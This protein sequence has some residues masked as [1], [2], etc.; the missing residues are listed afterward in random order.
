MRRSDP[1]AEKMRK[2]MLSHS[3]RAVYQSGTRGDNLH[4]QVRAT[5][6]GGIGDNRRRQRCE[7]FREVAAINGNTRQAASVG[8]DVNGQFPERYTAR[9]SRLTGPSRAHPYI[10]ART[11]RAL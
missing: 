8:V 1:P 9:S 10:N 4:F 11:V 5:Q 7:Q 2:S 3:R 6:A